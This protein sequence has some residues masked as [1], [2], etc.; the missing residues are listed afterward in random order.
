MTYMITGDVSQLSKEAHELVFNGIKQNTRRTYD[1]AY[2][3]Y[4]LFCEMYD[5]NLMPATEE[6][7]LMYIAFLHRRKLSP[8]TVHVYLASVRSMHIRNGIFD[9]L[10]DRPRIDLAL[11]GVNLQT[12]AP[13][14]KLPITIGI[15]TRMKAYADNPGNY[16][17]F[18]CWTAMNLGYFGLLRAAEYCTSDL[19]FDPSKN[20]CFEDIYVQSNNALVFR[21]KSSKTAP[22]G[23]T[24]HIGCSSGAICAVCIRL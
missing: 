7:I 10:R 23:A 19:K 13:Q 8:S 22:H 9:P 4:K 15:L 17:T 18:L 24:V 14:Q 2:K 16:D 6:Q 12:K 5:F 21:L 3:Q 20:V 11:R 1:S